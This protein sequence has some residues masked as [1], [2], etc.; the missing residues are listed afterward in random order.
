MR[1]PPPT[2][3]AVASQKL[4]A[5]HGRDAVAIRSAEARYSS[6]ALCRIRAYQAL[7][8][9][10]DDPI[11]EDRCVRAGVEEATAKRALE[12]LLRVEVKITVL[13]DARLPSLAKVD[14]KIRAAHERFKRQ[15]R[16]NQRRRYLAA[17]AELR[18]MTPAD[19]RAGYGADVARRAQ[20]HRENLGRRRSMQPVSDA[21]PLV[22]ASRRGARQ[23]GAGRPGA[24]AGRRSSTSRDD[25]DNDSD[26]GPG[27]AGRLCACGCGR[28]ISHKR[29]DARTYD[30]TCRQRLT[31]AGAARPSGSRE[32]F[33]L[34]GPARL[35]H[36]LVERGLDPAA[37]GPAVA[38]VLSL[39]Q[40]RCTPPTEPHSPPAWLAHLMASNGVAV[41]RRPVLAV[42]A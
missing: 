23:R 26:D 16:L 30:A 34:G 18:D 27:E 7:D 24:A 39:D 8:E 28:D 20:R 31:R 5:E 22:S 29:A 32:P 1:T 4:D 25:G 2:A 37:I 36:A 42:L 35:L 38:L 15:A 3:E 13:D 41:R 40:G 12:E 10:P 17:A 19:R 21:A 33:G 14:R 11:A 9:N 6:W